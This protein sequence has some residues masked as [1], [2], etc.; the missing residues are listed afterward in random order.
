MN[1]YGFARVAVCSPKVFVGN[2]NKN[3]DSIISL[4]EENKDA[5]VIV[6]PELCITGY[7]CGDLFQQTALLEASNKAIL[8][9]LDHKKE[10]DQLIFVGAPFVANNKLFNCAFAIQNQM[11]LGIVPKINIPN[12]GEF[13]E[14]R[15]FRSPIGEE[16]RKINFETFDV[17]F[18]TNLIFKLDKL[19]VFAE[20]CED[21]WMPIPPS[22]KAAMAG[23]NLIVN[24]SASNETVGKN[25]YR[26][27]LVQNQSARC[28]TAY[29]YASA[30]PSESTGDLVFG[31]HCIIAENGK[32]LAQTT[33]VGNFRNKIDFGDWS[34]SADIDLEQIEGE[35]TRMTSF[36]DASLSENSNFRI[37]TGFCQP[38]KTKTL[39]RNI[40]SFP[41]V[42]NDDHVLPNRCEEI[43]GIQCAGLYKR[44]EQ[45]NFN[46]VYIGVSGGLDSTLALLVTVEAFRKAGKDC[47]KI[48]GITMPGFGTT[49]KTKENAI[50]L[51]KSLMVSHEEICIKQICLSTWAALGHKIFGTIDPNQDLQT[52]EDLIKDVPKE[53]RQDL[54]FENVQARERTK[55]LMSRG[56]VIGTGDMSELALGW[57]TYNGDHMSMYNV[58]CSVPKTLVKFL[59]EYFANKSIDSSLIHILKNIAETTISPELLPPTKT[60]EIEQSTE[61]HLGPYVLHDFY[62]Y[63]FIRHGFSPDKVLYLANCAFSG[64]YS[65]DILKKTMDT[66]LKRFFSQQFKRNCVP[67]GPKVGSVSMSPRGDWRMPSDA[68]PNIWLDKLS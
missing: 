21:L 48:H 20:I 54:I 39:K 3:A 15:W 67:D 23:A 28:L 60:G 50:K 66:F 7:T 37:I 58:N 47:K 27:N 61:D 10:L 32:I 59:V 51:M 1:K 55:I 5:D 4:I 9:I 68:N 65:K 35:R 8:K 22:S 42:P 62:L 19:M 57:C 49:K 12:Y 26:T 38:R 6:F 33:H 53:N 17:F 11:I 18:G 13:Y 63:Y 36:G 25:E 64:I 2:P 43:L 16:S 30:G 40:P 29:A 34:T 14:G 52:F 45:I 31:G 56:F 41:F 46:D 44:L 24:L